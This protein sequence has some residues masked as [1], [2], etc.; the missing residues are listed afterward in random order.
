[1]MATM[2]HIQVESP[3]VASPDQ[4]QEEPENNA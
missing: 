1:M 3:V 4:K 2:K